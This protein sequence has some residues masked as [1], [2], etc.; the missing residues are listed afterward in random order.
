V[1]NVFADQYEFLKAGDVPVGTFEAEKLARG[2]V[3]W[4]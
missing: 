1:S 2:V 4:H 3:S